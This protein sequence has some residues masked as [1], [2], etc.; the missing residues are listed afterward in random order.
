M[1]KVKHYFP[2]S[3]LD[4]PAVCW[5]YLGHGSQQVLDI[6]QLP[7]VIGQ[8]G[9]NGINQQL[10]RLSTRLQLLLS[11]LLTPALHT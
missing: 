3:G 1:S 7:V 2:H 4:Q 8:N 11:L 10:Q 5:L 6:G 9:L